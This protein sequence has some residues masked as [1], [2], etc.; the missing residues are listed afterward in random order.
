[1]ALKLFLKSDVSAAG[2]EEASR[3]SLAMTGHCVSLASVAC[4]LLFWPDCP[5]SGRLPSCV[6]ILSFVQALP[7]L[8]EF[9][10]QQQKFGCPRIILS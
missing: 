4:G 8:F 5:H 3:K 1:M 6:S 2:R 7:T 10:P 9:C